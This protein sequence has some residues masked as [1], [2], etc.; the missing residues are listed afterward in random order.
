MWIPRRLRTAHV[1]VK[2][3]EA[4]PQDAYR[5]AHDH[6][7][8]ADGPAHFRDERPHLQQ[9]PR[10]DHG[11]RQVHSILPA[12]TKHSLAERQHQE[13]DE[14]RDAD[15]NGGALEFFPEQIHRAESSPTRETDAKQKL[16]WPQMDTDE[17]QM[18]SRL[19]RF[20]SS[21]AKICVICGQ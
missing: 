13:N 3:I 4:D 14:R 16:L 9:Q 5:G 11:L 15:I 7:F 20:R 6:R 17:T 10:A 12:F 19:R 21:S 2:G 18:V 8:P 1:R